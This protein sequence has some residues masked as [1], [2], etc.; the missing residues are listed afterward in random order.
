MVNNSSN[1][2]NPLHVAIDIGTTKVIAVA[3]KFNHLDQLEILGQARVDSTGVMRGV[4]SNIEKTVQAINQAIRQAE[5]AVGE[6]FREVSVSISGQHINSSI[7][8]SMIT[9]DS[10]HTEIA[11]SDIEKLIND[12]NKISLPAGEKILHI[13]PQEYKVDQESSIIDPIGMSGI[14]LEGNFH[15]ITGQVSSI[16]N[17]LRCLDRAQLTSRTPVFGAIASSKSVLT[18]QEREAG[19]ALVDIGGGTTD[20]VIFKDGIMRYS[21]SLPVGGNLITNDIRDAFSVMLNIAERL[22]VSYGNALSSQV[23][24][25]RLIATPTP[26]VREQKQ[27]SER[28]LAFVVQARM[29]DIVEHVW[30]V[31][32]ANGFERKLIGGLVITGGGANL[33]ST[34]SIFEAMTGMQTRIGSPEKVLAQGYA[35]T[36]G[37]PE[38][39][40]AIGLLVQ[41]QEEFLTRPAMPIVEK[42]QPK[43]EESVISEQA[44]Y[45][46]EPQKASGWLNSVIKFFEADDDKPLK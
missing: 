27:I 1:K 9:R 16:N 39:S 14:R 37:N 21:A 8:T 28:N 10:T 6:K 15:V 19:V 30:N 17:T 3:G 32:V 40:T 22:K 45:A 44:A 43:I 24:Q 5:Q 13:L 31:I 34:D 33:P 41:A 36:L 42:Q 29:E 11:H 26:T 20:I 35:P 7:K 38:Y 4:V 46:E 18:E 12:I 25:H 2:T 23:Y